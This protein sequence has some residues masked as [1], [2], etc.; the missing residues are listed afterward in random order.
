MRKP[1]QSKQKR[2]A[3]HKRAA[4]RN[5]RLRS[6]QA[7]KGTKKAKLQAEKKEKA[8]KYQEMI[9]KVLQARATK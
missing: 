6:T 3:A 7:E 8:K 5:A 2:L 4:K 1:E 9:N